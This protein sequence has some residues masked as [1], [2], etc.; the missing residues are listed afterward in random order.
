MCKRR[1][2]NVLLKTCNEDIKRENTVG[3]MSEYRRIICLLFMLKAN[4]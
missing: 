2:G 4:R 1:S 3:R